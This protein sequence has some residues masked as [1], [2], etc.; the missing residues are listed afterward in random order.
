MKRPIARGTLPQLGAKTTSMVIKHLLNGMQEVSHHR[1]YNIQETQLTKPS[2]LLLLIGLGQVQ[3]C[4]LPWKKN[5]A[6]I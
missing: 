1:D 2:N 6:Q 5:E 4:A 3:G